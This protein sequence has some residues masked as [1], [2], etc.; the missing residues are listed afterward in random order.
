[1]HYECVITSHPLHAVTQSAY[2]APPQKHCE[3][4]SYALQIFELNP[5]KFET[6]APNTTPPMYTPKFK[7]SIPE[8][9]EDSIDAEERDTAEFKI[10]TDGSGYNRNTGTSAVLYRNRTT[11]EYKSLKFHL[12]RLSRHTTYEAEAVSALLATWLLQSM[13]GLAWHPSSLYTDSQAFLRSLT[14]CTAGSGHYLVDT[15]WTAA[16]NTPGPLQVNWILGHSDVRGN[17]RADELAKQ[18]VQGHS[19]PEADLP[20]FLCRT[21]LHSATTE[22]QAYTSEVNTM[23]LEQWQNLPRRPQMEHFNKLFPFKKFRKI[24]N[25]LTCAQ[26]SLL[27]QLCTGHIPL[28][29]HLFR[30]RCIDTDYCQACTPWQGAMLAKE[31]ITHYL[32]ECPAY[33][34][35]W[36][37]LDRALGCHSRDLESIM[38]SKKHM[39]DS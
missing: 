14:K 6:I 15:F 2:R 18:A 23:W 3:P 26:S 7:I 24:Q 19:S 31:T 16:D 39:R 11:H 30:L 34:N 32:F 33:H 38:A 28:N 1:M 4:I 17:E 10:Y 9:R 35:E 13:P 36:H 25:E 5:H 29:A 21:L 12:G 37:D 8:T 22:K 20:P 27:I